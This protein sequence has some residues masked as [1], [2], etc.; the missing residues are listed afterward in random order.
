M[1]WFTQNNSVIRNKIFLLIS[2]MFAI[3]LTGCPQTWSDYY[4]SYVPSMSEIDQSI[5]GNSVFMELC[6]AGGA[7]CRRTFGLN[8]QC[9]KYD[10]IIW[11][12]SDN[13]HP[14][15]EAVDWFED[16][17]NEKPN[18]TLVFV[19]R[20]FEA[21]ELYWNRILEVAPETEKFEIRTMIA[22]AKSR[23]LDHSSTSLKQMFSDS[24]SKGI[25]KEKWFQSKNE[26]ERKSFTI[27]E[28]SG[29]PKI[30]SGLDSAK[31]ELKLY[32]EI[33]PV[34]NNTQILLSGNT[35][36]D[37]EQKMLIAEKKVGQSRILL[38]PSG[39]FLLNYPLVNQEN[40]KLAGR[41][42]DLLAPRD[43]RILFLRMGHDLFERID[44]SGPKNPGFILLQIWPT[45]LFFWHLIALGIVVCF[46]KWP[47]FGRQRELAPAITADFRQHINA[48][49]ELL[50][51]SAD[52]DF[53][54]G[55]IDK[56]LHE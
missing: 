1:N 30:V 14:G 37:N 19:G 36:E 44:M 23:N 38:V 55:Q 52:V 33:E 26:S 17:L 46:W 12:C 56:F 10:C 41:F 20:S 54:K 40:R 42:I 15:S 27:T 16:W 31:A 47:V 6:T 22:Y 8:K 49:A 21:D 7:R 29:D 34:G 13:Q 11:F 48:Y 43:K 53:A 24:K 9:K 32:G 2:S 35:E 25:S 18:R 28:L 51:D 45:C 5:N 3:V 39:V 4:R 50:K